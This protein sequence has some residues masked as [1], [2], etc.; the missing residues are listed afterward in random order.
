V[1]QA[2]VFEDGRTG[3]WPDDSDSGLSFVSLGPKTNPVAVPQLS[4]V[5]RIVR[6]RAVNDANGR[7]AGSSSTYRQDDRAFPPIWNRFPDSRA[8]KAKIGNNEV[9]RPLTDAS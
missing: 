7:G 8:G 5:P 3:R 2:G 4:T 9:L 6:I 1:T